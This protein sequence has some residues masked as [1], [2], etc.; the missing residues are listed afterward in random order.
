M[1]ILEAL[2]HLNGQILD[3]LAVSHTTGGLH[4]FL[5]DRFVSTGKDNSFVVNVQ[6]QDRG[7][8]LDIDFLDDSG[9]LVGR[10]RIRPIHYADLPVG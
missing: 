2:D 1:F 3:V 8:I 7:D 4:D 5:V 9:K 6:A 10:G